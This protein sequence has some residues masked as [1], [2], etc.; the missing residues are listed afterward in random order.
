MTGRWIE[1]DPKLCSRVERW[2]DSQESDRTTRPPEVE[3]V[4][5]S[6]A[7]RQVSR[8]GG[9]TEG[10]SGALPTDRIVVKTFRTPAWRDSP[11]KWLASIVKQA[12]RRTPAA[13]EW[14]A[15]RLFSDSGVAVPSALARA[16]L[17]G[18]VSVVVTSY[19]DGLPL[20]EALKAPSAERRRHLAAAGRLVAALHDAGA[21][22]RDLHVGNILIG[23]QGAI[24]ID[25][26]R[27]LETRSQ[28]ARL[29]DLGD[30]DF[31]L[32]HLGMSRSDRLRFRMAALGLKEG[33]SAAAREALRAVGD[34]AE[35][36]AYR[37]YRGRTR[38]TLHPGPDRMLVD[39]N[40]SRGMRLAPFP[41]SA[42]AEAID[43]HRR[44]VREGGAE[45]LK[46]DHR[47]QVSAVEVGGRR[48]VVKEVVKT[49]L[50]K[51][52]ADV[53]RGS[54]GRRAWVAGHGLAIRGIGS[55]LPLAYVERRRLGV[56]VSSLVILEDLRPGRP[57]DSKGLGDSLA[58]RELPDLLLGLV[59]R[60]H[61]TGVTHGDL[62]AAHILLLEKSR[63]RA[64]GERHLAL[65]DL[66]G[67][68]FRP[69]LSDEQRIQSLAELNAS[70]GDT[71]ISSAQ[72]SRVLDLYLATLPLGATREANRREIVRRSLERENAWQG[73]GC[74]EDRDQPRVS[75]SR[76][77]SGA[78]S[79]GTSSPGT[80]SGTS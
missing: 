36:R 77:S 57:V 2:L 50:R 76:S 21:V 37:Y 48:V 60:L 9:R 30:L 12:L 75:A 19:V 71:E 64:E 78:S 32:A 61:R 58:P 67:V 73:E 38:R 26:Q 62:Q 39:F 68:R 22:H 52:L 25:L 8:L 43:E 79:S 56:P 51:R 49:S 55:A 35:A 5:S 11:G 65:I 74:L 27:V 53:V 10:P 70:I 41:E 3:E 80:S 24:L 46:C 44:R 34:A 28:Q 13:R 63:D 33:R 69:R 18:R 23:P 42:V 1:G 14:R 17:P 6:N 29:R 54:P 59:V 40:G 16:N 31:S 47:S 7:L 72:R 15:L 66:E 45:L 20:T 4:L